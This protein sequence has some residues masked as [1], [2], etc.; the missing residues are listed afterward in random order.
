MLER[1][2]AG[3]ESCSLQRVVSKPAKRCRQLHTGFWQHGASAIDLSSIWPGP[4]RSFEHDHNDGESTIRQLQ[5]GLIASAFLLDFLYPSAT[6][7]LLRRIYP[8][9][10]RTQE[11]QQKTLIPRR[12]PFSSTAATPTQESFDCSGAATV[13]AVYSQDGRTEA[14]E[15]TQA[16]I[17][18]HSPDSHHHLD[19]ANSNNSTTATIPNASLDTKTSL[20]SKDYA[21]LKRLRDLISDPHENHYQDVWD[22]YCHLDHEEKLGIRGTIVQYLAQ[23]H[24]FVETGRAVSVFRQ[25]PEE[26]WNDSLLSAGII[27]FL[28]SGE[29]AYAVD[30]FKLGLRLK[31][32]SGGLEYLLADA[33]SSKQW[34]TALDVWQAYYASQ[35]KE[36]PDHKP[37]TKRLQQLDTLRNQGTLYFAFR[38]YLATEGADYY[39]KIKESS[40]SNSAFRA[41]RR[42]FAQMALREPCSPEQAK[43]ILESLND[44]GLYNSYFVRMFDRWYKKLE[45]RANIAKLPEIY[46]NFRSLP[47]AK[48]SLDVL[49]GLFKIN[50]P[51]GMANLEQIYQDWIRFHGYLGRWSYEKFLKLYALRG[52]IQTVRRLWDEYVR[53]FPEMLKIPRGFRSILNV[54]AQAGNVAEVERE[55]REM[56]SKYKVTPDIDCW[57]TVLKG[58]MRAND[59]DGVLDCFNKISKIY[60]PDSFTYAHVMAMAAKKGDL[61]TTLDFFSRSQEAQVSV[62]KEMALALVVAYCQNDLLLEA[63]RLCTEL[64]DRKLT[65]TT[66]WNQLL[67][68]NGVE[69]KLNKCYELLQRMKEFGVEWDDET[70]GFLLQALVKVNQIHPAYT[71]LKQAD[72]EGL[73][74]VTPDHFAIVMAGAA[75]TGEYTLVESLHN[76]LKKSNLPMT[77]NAIVALVDAAARR[78]PGVERTRNLSQEF[79]TLFREALS[80]SQGKGPGQTAPGESLGISLDEITRIKGNT[81]TM[82]RA[83]MLLVEL[84]DFGSA[85]ELMTLYTELFPEFKKGDQFPP[86]VVSALM[87][88]HYKD[89]RYDM[90]MELWDKTWQRVLESS[91]NRSGTGIYAGNE[92]DLS[93]ILNIVL[94]VFKEQGNAQGLSDCIDQVTSAGFK[95]TRSNWGLV[96]AYLAELGRWE[97]AM[98]WCETML[99]PGWRGWNPERSHKEKRGL[100]NTR[101]LK[102]PKH[103]VFK[104]QQDWLKMR[105][106]AAW[107]QDVSRQLQNVQEK[108]PRL[109]HAF[110]TS[111]VDD[112]P[113]G[114]LTEGQVPLRDLDKLLKGMP[115]IELQKIKDALLKQLMQERKREKRLG[116]ANSSQKTEQERQKWKR[117]LHNKVRRYAILWVKRREAQLQGKTSE[118]EDQPEKGA[119]EERTGY[120]ANIWERYDQN[121]HKPASQQQRKKKDQPKEGADV[122]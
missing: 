17:S 71:L 51:K 12:R 36:R 19:T 94:R 47:D 85:E 41:F 65:H 24:S 10:P 86:N 118:A 74:S 69:G 3:L 108:Y 26:D 29:P 59:Y 32:L 79:I 76:R 4:P 91:K 39:R 33:I 81:H 53:D 102:A 34:T 96:V 63:E 20:L 83:I 122:K 54:Y 89:E 113:T 117:A 16:V 45:P 37:N 84:R 5:S 87:L 121:P 72:E 109:Y 7:P 100:V 62:S 8:S 90:V 112:M 97:S 105:K 115:Y 55:L 60:E 80:V 38:S 46:Q 22:L 28:R 93:R 104:L 111:D 119:V 107:S 106:M 50:Y 56:T 58:Y 88:A 25:I 14:W 31:G 103:V 15:Q 40:I 99:M 95:L 61:E 11:G 2:A 64:A 66:I 43:I 110:T 114:D 13:E 82:G 73:F 75:R 57:N 30:R 44:P 35:L 78:K 92:Y 52:D 77:F 21:E 98:E 23:S 49:R 1:T 116:I 6:L 42:H 9:L 70:Y 18:G 27:L 48:P 67:N 120:W 101:T 68:F